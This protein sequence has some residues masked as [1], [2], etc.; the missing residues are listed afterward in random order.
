[1]HTFVDVPDFARDLPTL[2]GLVL[3]DARA[4]TAT[5]AE[6]LAGVLDAAPTTRRDFSGTDTVAALIRVYQ[7]RDKAPPVVVSFQVLDSAMNAVDTAQVSLDGATFA[8]AGAADARYTLPLATLR[9]GSYVL[10]VR[11]G[12]GSHQ[13]RDLPFLVR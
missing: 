2:S 12:D 4:P 10:R 9:S 7:K 6:A 5:P 8:M 13:R 1:M 11:A 3:L